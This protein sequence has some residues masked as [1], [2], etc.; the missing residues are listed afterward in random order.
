MRVKCACKR[1]VILTLATSVPLRGR[2]VAVQ[3]NTLMTGFRYGE[4]D[5]SV[6]AGAG[7]LVSEAVLCRK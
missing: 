3:G 4:R 6:G 1:V 5:L 7:P 2:M